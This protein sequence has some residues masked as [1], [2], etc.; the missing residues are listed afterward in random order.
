MNR[1][2]QKIV[3]NLSNDELRELNS[4][5]VDLIRANQTTTQLRAK[6]G[7]RMGDKVKFRSSKTGRDVVGFVKKI[8]SKSIDVL[9][10]TA[11][12]IN[13]V[14]SPMPAYLQMTWRVSPS[15]LSKA[16]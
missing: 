4:Y 1:D 14:N 12:G 7:F 5:V 9:E 3:L 15:M 2:L 10:D 11:N 6:A 13:L 8:N 16:A